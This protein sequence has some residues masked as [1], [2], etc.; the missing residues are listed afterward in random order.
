MQLRARVAI[1]CCWWSSSFAAVLLIGG[2]GRLGRAVARKLVAAGVET[3][4]LVRG[5]PRKLPPPL[6]GLRTVVGDVTDV[7]SLR[8]AFATGGFDS[9]ISTHGVTPPRFSKLRDLLPGFSDKDLQ[10]PKNVNLRGVEN[11][12]TVMREFK[13][14]KLVRI[15]GALVGNSN[16]L[17]AL[18]F[19][20]LLS[21]SVKFH[22]LAEISIRRSGIDYLIIRPTGIREEPPVRATNDSELVCVCEGG[23]GSRRV[24]LPGKISIDDLGDLCVMGAIGPTVLPARSTVTVSSAKVTESSSPPRKLS[25]KEFNYTL[26]AGPLYAGHHSRN[27]LI[28]SGL[29][30]SAVCSALWAIAARF[31]IF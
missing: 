12:L 7:E 18:I 6:D 20:L 25:F 30:L 5:S 31:L 11:I 28:L 17:F 19:N 27:A 3:T 22:E 24:K 23:G 16:S 9:V 29:A 10:H 1:L 2:T 14:R 15:T 21:F 4:L 13:T 26:D 8:S